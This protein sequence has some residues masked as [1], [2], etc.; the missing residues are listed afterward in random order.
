MELASER[1]EARRRV[2]HTETGLTAVTI[3]NLWPGCGPA[4]GLPRPVILR[5]ALNMLRVIRRH[6]KAL[7][8]QS[9]E[10][11]VEAVE[12]RRHA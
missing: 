9:R 4:R 3:D 2:G 11:V 8:L 1:V 10:A 5:S 12:M 7:E 6:R